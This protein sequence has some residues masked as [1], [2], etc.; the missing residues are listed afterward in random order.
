MF[1]LI[2]ESIKYF[3][4]PSTVRL[5]EA[6]QKSTKPPPLPLLGTTHLFSKSI[7][8]YIQSGLTSS[9]HVLAINTMEGSFACI[10]YT[11]SFFVCRFLSPR[12]FHTRQFIE[13]GRAEPQPPPNPKVYHHQSSKPVDVCQV[14]LIG[15]QPVPY[16]SF[17]SSEWYYVFVWFPW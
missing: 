2:R 3:N 15:N 7:F 5:T 10:I 4:E 12:Q 13:I 8:R 17:H 11:S 16:S 6:L 1:L 9:A 14:N